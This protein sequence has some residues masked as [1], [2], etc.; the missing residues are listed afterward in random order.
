MIKGIPLKFRG[1]DTITSET[2]TDLNDFLQ[3]PGHYFRNAR[4][5]IDGRTFKNNN[6]V[7]K[8][9]NKQEENENFKTVDN[10]LWR[11]RYG[12]FN[13]NILDVFSSNTLEM[14]RV[15]DFLIFNKN[16]YINDL[17]TLERL[18]GACYYKDLG[19]QDHCIIDGWEVEGDWGINKIK[20]NSE[21]NFSKVN[22][23]CNDYNKLAVA[24]G[25][26]TL[27]NE[28]DPSELNFVN[29][30]WVNEWLDKNQ[31]FLE[32]LM[33]YVPVDDNTIEIEDKH[34]IF[35]INHVL[36]V[37]FIQKEVDS[38]I[39]Y[40]FNFANMVENIPENYEM[41]SYKINVDEVGMVNLKRLKDIISEGSM[42]YLL[43]ILRRRQNNY[44]YCGDVPQEE[45]LAE[46]YNTKGTTGYGAFQFD[47]KSLSKEEAC[48]LLEKDKYFDYLYGVRMKLN[49]KEYP[50][51]DV[52]RY[53]E[54][55]GNGSALKCFENVKNKRFTQ[56]ECAI[57]NFH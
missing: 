56:R 11:S 49:F 27:M 19:N 20:Y 1:D 9:R 44:I 50:L 24:R 18:L 13:K 48:K 36:S 7:G 25:L 21:F 14:V 5:D 6:L 53:D 33:K 42:S 54:H 34:C 29:Y 31:L 43:T 23:S 52:E 26:I 57:L 28:T 3:N 4:N 35:K 41:P 2:E 55:Y 17:F 39:K 10:I 8:I 30:F 32:Y 22:L 40:C 46:L 51:I 45:M 47:G 16:Y 12:K 38:M 37:D 15:I